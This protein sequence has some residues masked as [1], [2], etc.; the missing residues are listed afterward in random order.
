MVIVLHN[1]RETFL[2]FAQALIII[3]LCNFEWVQRPLIQDS[4]RSEHLLEVNDLL[5]FLPV[6]RDLLV[7]EQELTHIKLDFMKHSESFLVFR[8]DVQVDLDG[9]LNRYPLALFF[10]LLDVSSSLEFEGP[11]D[12]LWES[13]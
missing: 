6:V 12:V 11:R 5:V 9:I 2:I 4:I 10:S 7:R 3:D 1:F 13:E 8:Q